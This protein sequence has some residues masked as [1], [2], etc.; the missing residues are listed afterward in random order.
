MS[1]IDELIRELC[2]EGVPRKQLRNCG[3]FKKGGSLQKKDMM[4]IGKPAIHYGQ[5][6]MNPVVSLKLPP[7][8][9]SDEIFLTSR[10]ADPGDLII[11]DTSEDLEGVATA[12]AWLGESQIAVSGHILIFSHNLEPKYVSYFF[13]TADF[14]NQKNRRSKGVKVKDI[15]S[16]RLGEVEIP[17]PPLE[18][19]KEIV[20]ILDKFTQL[21][22][23]LEAELEA[24]RT[25][26]EVTRDR[27]LDFSGDLSAHPMGEKIRDLCPGGVTVY[28]LGD[29]IEENLGGGTPSRSQPNF[30]G[31]EIA[32]ASVG[33]LT[34]SQLELRTARQS[35]TQEGLQSSSTN[36]IPE[37]WVVAAV[38]IAPG[39]M[40][41]VKS[42]VAINQDLRGLRLKSSLDPR[43]L[44]FYSKT[45][46]VRSNGTI[47]KGITND[48]LKRIPI[49][50]PPLLI[51]KEIVSI[52]DKLDAL[53][54]D[55]SYGL[56]AE[57]AARRKQ[58]E[59][60]RNR[61]LTFKELDAA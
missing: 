35:I 21:E 36:L 28:S 51:Q 19:Q 47:V 23:E 29:L 46:Q 3:T 39:E 55:I 9:V 43:F 32:W 27:L 7:T 30:W 45:L 31:G 49:P 42:P 53:V 13:K 48:S 24:R 61:L 25:Q 17:V 57:I 50:L 16:E 26:Y 12:V 18:V 14:R 37:G 20:S 54:T 22:A 33:D 40:R 34:S 6:H 41:V 8:R 44:V 5:I 2:P 56:P 1:R 15:S 4:E 59:H 10:K 38:K 58:Y 60:Y 52:L 11:A